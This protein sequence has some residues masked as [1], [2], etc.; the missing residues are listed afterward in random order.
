MVYR[1][2]RF[3]R[4]DEKKVVI[5]RVALQLVIISAFNNISNIIPNYIYYYNFKIFDVSKPILEILFT[6]S[7]YSVLG[8]CGF[9]LKIH[10]YS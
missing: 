4:N 9:L 7:L 10:K 5:A 6:N 1:L 2:L 3:V 8:I